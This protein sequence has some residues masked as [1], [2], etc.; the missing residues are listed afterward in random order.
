MK[1]TLFD[2]NTSN[3]CGFCYGSTEKYLQVF[4]QFFDINIIRF[5]NKTYCY[6]TILEHFIFLDDL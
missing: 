1:Y 4:P 2:F 6:S 5:I 3:D